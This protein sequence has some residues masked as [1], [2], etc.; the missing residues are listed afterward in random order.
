[1]AHKEVIVEVVADAQRRIGKNGVSGGGFDPHRHD[2]A[3]AFS[4]PALD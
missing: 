1:M 2:G 3:I 4:S